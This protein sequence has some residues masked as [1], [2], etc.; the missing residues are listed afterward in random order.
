MIHSAPDSPRRRPKGDKRARTRA[1]I[2]EAA[3]LV[4]LEKGFER[5]TVQEIARRAG[6]S[7]GAIYGNF[8]D[9]AELFAAI[10]PAYWPRVRPRVKPGASFPEIMRALAEATV[11]VMPERQRRGAARYSGLAHGLTNDALRARSAENAVAAYDRAAAWWRSVI[12]EDQL[13]APVELW[14]P[15]V[16]AMIEGL[17]YC[18]LFAPQLTPDEVIYAAF[19]ALTHRRTAAATRTKRRP[20]PRRAP[21]AAD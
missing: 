4:T 9:R 21:D 5:A 3:A 6:V 10:G 13:P 11:S 2:V 18:R 19:E 20:A 14:V 8:R 7:N 17:T 12:A 15:I 16:A 1:R